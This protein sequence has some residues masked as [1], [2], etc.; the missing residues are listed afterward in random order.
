MSIPEKVREYLKLRKYIVFVLNDR[1][2]SL[3]DFQNKDT[4]TKE[5]LYSL[6]KQYHD[7]IHYY[8]KQIDPLIRKIQEEQR[9]VELRNKTINAALQRLQ[10]SL[11]TKMTLLK[12]R[13]DL[14]E[15][16]MDSIE[17]L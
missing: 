10:C 15:R 4:E 13:V 17:P 3:S 11:E 5:K 2:P 16:T 7:I 12:E 1:L 8:E 14:L 6:H 9:Y